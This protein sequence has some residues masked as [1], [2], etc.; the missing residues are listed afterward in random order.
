MFVCGHIYIYTERDRDTFRE[1]SPAVAWSSVAFPGRRIDRSPLFRR[2]MKPLR[3]PVRA[4]T[5]GPF[6]I[7]IYFRRWLWLRSR[8]TTLLANLTSQMKAAQR[9]QH[10]LKQM[11]QHQH[12]FSTGI[13]KGLCFQGLLGC[14]QGVLTMAHMLKKSSLVNGCWKLREESRGCARDHIGIRYIYIYI[15]R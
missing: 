8:K 5:R 10:A 2:P 13:P 1:T 9:S 4:Q 15:Y 7:R 12:P 3:F 11:S 14:I 6:G